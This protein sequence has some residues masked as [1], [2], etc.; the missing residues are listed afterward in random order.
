MTTATAPTRY[1][2]EFLSA[3][4][5]RVADEILYDLDEQIGRYADVILPRGN[6][7]DAALNAVR[8]AAAV[9]SSIGGLVAQRRNEAVAAGCTHRAV[10]EASR[11]PIG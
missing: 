6:R 2:D 7:Q 10:D 1:S 4:A 5:A 11:A 9:Q 8:L 3:I